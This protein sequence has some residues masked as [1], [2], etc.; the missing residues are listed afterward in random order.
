[1]LLNSSCNDDLLNSKDLLVFVRTQSNTTSFTF[2]ML[3]TGEG[4]SVR[5]LKLP[6]SLT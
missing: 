2:S 3:P 5:T 1:M 6:L 4:A